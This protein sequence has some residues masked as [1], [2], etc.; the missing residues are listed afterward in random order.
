MQRASRADA[1]RMC[2]Q[3][4]HRAQRTVGM[5]DHGKR[6]CRYGV[7]LMAPPESELTVGIRSGTDATQ[8]PGHR[9]AKG[10][11]RIPWKLEQDE[12]LL[13]VIKTLKG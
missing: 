11:G 2:F 9:T 4:L 5:A 12:L 13:V 3:T 6:H 10:E 1:K 7:P 8:K